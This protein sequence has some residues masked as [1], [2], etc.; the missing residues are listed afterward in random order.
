M[1]SL[2]GL[3]VGGAGLPRQRGRGVEDSRLDFDFLGGGGEGVK[4]APR[5]LVVKWLVESEIVR[6]TTRNRIR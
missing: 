2:L 3:G 4:A 6:P 1:D 5:Q